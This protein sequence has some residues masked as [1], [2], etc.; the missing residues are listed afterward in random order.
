MNKLGEWHQFYSRIPVPAGIPVQNPEF[1]VPE[2]PAGIP[3]TGNSGLFKIPPGTRRGSNRTGVKLDGGQIGRGKM[4]RGQIGGGQS[5]WGS[6]VATPPQ[7]HL[8]IVV[9]GIQ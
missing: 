3:R 9:V 1:R 4:G 5:V 8:C 7:L 2:I 6:N